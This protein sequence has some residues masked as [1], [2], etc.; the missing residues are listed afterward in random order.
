MCSA[1]PIA[2]QKIHSMIT[3][4]EAQRRFETAVLNLQDCVSRKPKNET[5]PSWWMQCFAAA[6]AL[7]DS[8]M[9]R[10]SDFVVEISCKRGLLMDYSSIVGTATNAFAASETGA[11]STA[12]SNGSKPELHGAGIQRSVCHSVL[13]FLLVTMEM[14]ATLMDIMRAAEEAAYDMISAGDQSEREYLA[15]REAAEQAISSGRV[16]STRRKQG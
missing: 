11:S 7:R 8:P 5:D 3:K 13:S 16:M 4:A 14:L 15:T 2:P 10:D 9:E 1:E 6:K 12:G